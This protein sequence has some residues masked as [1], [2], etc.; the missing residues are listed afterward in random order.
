MVVI[1]LK[2]SWTR[3]LRLGALLLLILLV[4]QGYLAAE[5]ADR[6][7][8]T[9]APTEKTDAACAE[10]QDC[11]TKQK[12]Q[13][14]TPAEKINSCDEPK[15][16][17]NTLEDFFGVTGHTFQTVTGFGTTLDDLKIEWH[18][19]DFEKNGNREDTHRYM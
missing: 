18:E 11:N 10:K 14:K 6:S 16:S 2:I 19:L 12:K 9:P 7:D 1:H 3:H 15:P 13:C 5:P 17:V 4:G 8:P